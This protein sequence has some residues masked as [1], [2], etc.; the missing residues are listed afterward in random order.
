MNKDQIYTG[1][2]VAVG[3]VLFCILRNIKMNT[4]SKKEEPMDKTEQ[5]RQLMLDKQP[6]NEAL[7]NFAN[8]D[9]YNERMIFLSEEE[10]DYLITELSKNEEGMSRKTREILGKVKYFDLEN[11]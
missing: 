5:I 10:L 9:V 4:A 2:G 1:V 8:S 7:V 6:V 11:N 3:V